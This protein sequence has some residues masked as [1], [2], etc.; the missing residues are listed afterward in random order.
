[1][2]GI[3]VKYWNWYSHLCHNSQEKTDQ[4]CRCDGTNP[5]EKY[6][7][8]W[9]YLIWLCHYWAHLYSSFQI[10]VQLSSFE[11]IQNINL[12]KLLPS[13]QPV[14]VLHT[15]ISVT[16]HIL[17]M[18][19]QWTKKTYNRQKLVVQL[20]VTG[21]SLLW[22]TVWIWSYSNFSKLFHLLTN[23]IKL[24]HEIHVMQIYISGR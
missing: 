24:N 19:T 21:L 20:W 9:R 16:L 17:L 18:N 23:N 8:Q 7:L 5:K 1:M 4:N 11:N 15:A 2:P 3:K 12:S 10:T 22:N 6:E 13:H 14:N